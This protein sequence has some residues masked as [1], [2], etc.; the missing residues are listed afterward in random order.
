MAPDVAQQVLRQLKPKIAIPMHY[1]D[2]LSLVREFSKGFKVRY[3]NGDTLTV[4]KSSLPS[5]TEIFVL[6]PRGAR[7]YE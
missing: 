6:K 2:N 4:R 1:R 7:D 5:S 3:V